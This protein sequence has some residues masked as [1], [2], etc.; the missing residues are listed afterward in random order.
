MMLGT[1]LY[2]ANGRTRTESVMPDP[3]ISSK[4]RY[5]QT[6]WAQTGFSFAELYGF[7]YVEQSWLD[8]TGSSLQIYHPLVLGIVRRWQPQCGL[9]NGITA[10]PVSNE[11][12]LKKCK[13]RFA[14]TTGELWVLTFVGIEF[15]KPT[16]E[17]D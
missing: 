16:A 6:V 15:G 1:S 5:R 4:F 8:R 14:R 10:S 7:H 11:R 9:V 13:H 2:A 12:S 3:D 17:F